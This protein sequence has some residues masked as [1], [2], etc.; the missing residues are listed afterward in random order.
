MIDFNSLH[1]WA[2]ALP[3]PKLG[4]IATPDLREA[5]DGKL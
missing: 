3:G 1:L 2:V 4:A 5:V